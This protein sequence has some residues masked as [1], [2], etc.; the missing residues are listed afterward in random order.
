LAVALSSSAPDL[1]RRSIGLIAAAERNGDLAATMQ[2]ILDEPSSDDLG[3]LWRDFGLFRTYFLVLLVVFGTSMTLIQ[4]FDYSMYHQILRDF[5]VPMPAVTVFID[6]RIVQ[7]GQ[8]VAAAATLIA[9]ILA[10]RALRQMNGAV[11]PPPFWTAIVDRII[12]HIPLI[13]G[14][15]RDR[16]RSDV[17][18]TLAASLDRRATLSQ[19]ME[20]ASQLR[21]N[22]LFHLRLLRCAA[23]LRSGEPVGTAFAAAGFPALIVGLCSTADRAQDLPATMHFLARYYRWQFS[24]TLLVLRA[25]VAPL[26]ATVGGAM[27]LVAWFW[28]YSPM[29]ILLDGMKLGRAT[30]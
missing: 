3:G 30:W 16:D 24:R 9:V 15:I 7:I 4:M 1:P 5:H 12:W 11:A 28:L 27:V 17:F 2:R 10:G 13:G 21:V 14:A 23:A 25:T 18:T 26:T 6:A 8:A 20:D 29:I 19:A 22:E